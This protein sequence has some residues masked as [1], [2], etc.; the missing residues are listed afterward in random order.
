MCQEDR[1]HFIGF[2]V[3]PLNMRK[4]PC[5]E[6]LIQHPRLIFFFSHMLIFFIHMHGFIM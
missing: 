3:S 5:Q 2:F 1:L 4:L 6:S